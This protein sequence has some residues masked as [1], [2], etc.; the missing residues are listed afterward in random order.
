MKRKA[1]ITATA[2]LLVAVMCLATA[3]YAWFTA[4]SASAVATLNLNVS[5]GDTGLS[6]ATA[7]AKAGTYTPGVFKTTTLTETD[8]TNN[9]YY[10]K[11]LQPVSTTGV[12]A[13]ADGKTTLPFYEA[14]VTSYDDESG[15]WSVKA[16]DNDEYVLF[17]FY[18]KN[19]DANDNSTYA[20]KFESTALFGSSDFNSTVKMAYNVKKVDLDTNKDVTPTIPDA[21]T[22]KAAKGC[23]DA[24]PYYPVTSAPQGG[25]ITRNTTSGEFEGSAGVLSTTQIADETFTDPTFKFEGEGAYLVTVAIWLEGQDKNCTGSLNVTAADMT[26]TLATA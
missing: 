11:Q 13:T 17:S 23:T 6:I 20:V 21:L 15:E 16:A 8:L 14:P 7:N 5:A 19:S 12:F 3:S 4:G 24:T 1:L 18:V 22:I 10:A 25:Y 2:V 26:V 9:G